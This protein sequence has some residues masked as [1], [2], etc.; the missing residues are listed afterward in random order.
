MNERK[1]YLPFLQTLPNE[2]Q[3][4]FKHWTTIRLYAQTNSQWL[5]ENDCK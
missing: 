3:I 1:E 4:V 5:V 2:K